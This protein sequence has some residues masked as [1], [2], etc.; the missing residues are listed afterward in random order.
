MMFYWLV[1]TKCRMSVPVLGVWP[2]GYIYIN[3]FMC[4]TQLS[5]QV[6][7]PLVFPTIEQTMASSPTCLESVSGNLTTNVKAGI[8][9]V[10]PTNSPLAD[11]DDQVNILYFEIRFCE[12]LN[13]LHDA[14][15]WDVPRWH[16]F[17]PTCKYRYT[18]PN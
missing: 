5:R 3:Q 6:L 1:H 9:T 2:L 11:S 8:E 18:A 10:I 16:A 7:P 13:V 4:V 15:T 17:I 14:Y 12:I